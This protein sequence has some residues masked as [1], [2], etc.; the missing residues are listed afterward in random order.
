ML[1]V[2][3]VAAGMTVLISVSIE[4]SCIK[5][6]PFFAYMTGSMTTWAGRYSRSLE[7]TA[8]M[9]AGV[10]SIPTLTASGGMSSKTASIWSAMTFGEMSSIEMTREVFSATTETMTLIPKTPSADIVLRSACTP[11]PPLQSEP[12]MVRAVLIMVVPP[13]KAKN[14]ASKRGGGTG[15]PYVAPYAGFNQ[16][17]QRVRPRPIST[18]ESPPA[19]SFRICPASPF[20]T[21]GTCRFLL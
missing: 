21:R 16:Q 3:R 5:G 18:P 9:Q 11:A 19:N 10:E 7:A 1:G 6:L 20:F 2:K 17:V 4:L 15:G 8:S 14:P 12:A 13:F